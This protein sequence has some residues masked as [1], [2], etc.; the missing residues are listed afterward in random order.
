[1]V[2]KALSGKFG[3]VVFVELQSCN[4]IVGRTQLVEA[5]MKRQGSFLRNK[6]MIWSRY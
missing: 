6:K 2:L 3:L 5:D 1:M 4:P